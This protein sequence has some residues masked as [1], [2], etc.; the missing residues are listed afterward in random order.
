MKGITEMKMTHDEML[1]AIE[2]WLRK[3]LM[4]GIQA[5]N[6]IPIPVS[7]TQNT[8][9]KEFIIKLNDASVMSQ[10]S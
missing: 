4:R 5:K 6:L 3:E 7:V 1:N 10:A 9:S 8:Q 2:L